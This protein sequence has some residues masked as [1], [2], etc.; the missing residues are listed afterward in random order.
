LVVPGYVAYALDKPLLLGITLANGMIS[1]AL[2]A[3]I[4]RSVIVFGRRL[5]VMAML[6]GFI[7]NFASMH[8][9]SSHLAKDVFSHE[10]GWVIPGLLALWLQRQGMLV[11]LSALAVAALTTALIVMFLGSLGV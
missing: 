2:L 5:F 4:S 10:Y 1:Y 8:L 9:L 7:V 3:L 6:I 11:T